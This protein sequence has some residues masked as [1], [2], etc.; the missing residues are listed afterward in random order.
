MSKNIH[1]PVEWKCSYRLFGREKVIKKYLVTNTD[2]KTEC[3]MMTIVYLD[4]I[5]G[6]HLKEF[7][8]NDRSA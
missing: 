6:K 8:Q 3:V 4:K 7:T 2:Y 1:S 5:M